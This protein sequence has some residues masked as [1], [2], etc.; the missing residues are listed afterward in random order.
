MTGSLRI[1]A[2]DRLLVFAP[3]PDDETLAAGELIQAALAVG[4]TVRVVFATD[5]E[6][7]PWPQRWLERRWR[8]GSA[9]RARWAERRRREGA[10][11]LGVLGIAGSES[12]R[13]LGWPDQGV[14]DL[15]MR[16]ADA[17]DVLVDE[18]SGFAPSH[19]VM[20]VIT[21]RHPDHSALRV[22]IELALLGENT[23]CARLGYAVHGH[24]RSSRSQ[25]IE[26]DLGRQQR[27]REA[28]ATHASQIALSGRRLLRVANRV[29]TFEVA[30]ASPVL[31]ESDA[32]TIIR[33]PHRSGW[34]LSSRC[35]LLLLLA[36]AEET[37]RCRFALPQMARSHKATLA[38]GYGRTSTVVRE[39]D[40]LN[41]EL[42]S[43]SH[44][45][46]IVAIY[47]KLHRAGPRL[48]IF[49]RE[50]WHDAPELLSAPP[51]TPDPLTAPGF[52]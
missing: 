17:V 29:E 25:S 14:T 50:R 39:N 26:R 6:N 37:L 9:E 48:M 47:A 8:I 40:V 46:P 43:P 32:S 15:L 7:N 24:E 36:T 16:N 35:D 28:L 45:A 41:I 52:V 12:V 22:M 11:A 1:S 51:A 3:H 38:D 27:K 4:A 19:V 10:A 34:A 31:A 20:P 42:P 23:D 13:F 49:D 33:V 21:D 5:G 2:H 44:A 30:N 18:I